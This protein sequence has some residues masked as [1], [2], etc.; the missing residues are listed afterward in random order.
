VADAGTSLDGGDEDEESEHGTLPQ[1]S[2]GLERLIPAM[3]AY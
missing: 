2:V 1:A 3:R